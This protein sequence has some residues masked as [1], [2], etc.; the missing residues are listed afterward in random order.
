MIDW[1][2]MKQYMDLYPEDACCY[3]EP[4]DDVVITHNGK[5]YGQPE[6]ETNASFYDRLKR[7]REAG[8]NLFIKE[9]DLKKYDNN[10]DY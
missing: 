3:D 5:A 1:N 8:E 9:W 10:V 7:S 6:T 2:L 4:N